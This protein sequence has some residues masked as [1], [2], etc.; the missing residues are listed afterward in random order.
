MGGGALERPANLP[1]WFRRRAP[2]PHEA[3][4]EAPLSLFHLKIT[5]DRSFFF[6]APQEGAYPG[7]DWRSPAAAAAAGD[8]PHDAASTGTGLN[9][10]EMLRVA[11]GFKDTL[12]ME[13]EVVV[14]GTRGPV[15]HA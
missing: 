15:E 9:P 7:T 13:V 14:R 11:G 10:Q 6:E 4:Q 12:P 8:Y 1:R 3:N 5:H 2:S